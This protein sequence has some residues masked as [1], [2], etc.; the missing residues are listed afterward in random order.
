M[1][2]NTIQILNNTIYQIYNIDDFDSMKREILT[3]LR[4]LIPNKCASLL[5]ARKD[6]KHSLT[7]PMCAPEKYKEMEERYMLY[8]DRDFSN[9]ILHKNRTV[10][11]NVSTLMDESE[12]EKTDVYINC[13]APYGLH[14]S[15]D[16]TIAFR[17]ELLGDLTLYRGKESENF[18]DEDEEIMKLLSDHLNARFYANKYGSRILE[19]TGIGQLGDI[20][21]EYGLTKREAEVLHMILQS[22]N[23]KQICEELYISENTLKKHLHNLYEKTG[24]TGRVQLLGLTGKQR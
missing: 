2:N 14:Y 20:I 10:I 7:D 16:M 1:D 18:N 9:W 22:R 13:F 8:E 24:V 6:M 4:L 15:L 11:L 19:K 17:G 23:N 3:S 21:N 5:M 12:R